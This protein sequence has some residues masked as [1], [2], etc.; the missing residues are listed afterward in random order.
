MKLIWEYPLPTTGRSMEQHFQ[1]S[2]LAGKDYLYYAVGTI[3]EISLHVI[4]VHTGQGT[5]YRFPQSTYFYVSP[6]QFFGFFYKGRAFFY[7]LDLYV[8]EDD[9]IVATVPLSENKEFNSWLLRDNRLYLAIGH[10]PFEELLCIDLDSLQIL[11]SLE[12]GCTKNYRA[13]AISFL[14]GKI[15]CYGLDQLLFVNPED[16]S[17]E[18]QLRFPRIDKIFCPLRQEDGTL[19]IGYTNWTNAGILCYDENAGKILWRYKRKFE[20]PLGNCKIYP[21]GDYVYWTKNDTELI[22]LDMAS[23]EAINRIR[24]A[25][26]RYTDLRFHDRNLLFGT[27]GADGFLNC[28]DSSKCTPKWQIPLKEGCVSFD[29]RHDSVFTGDFSKRIF[30]ISLIDGSISDTLTVDAEVIGCVKVQDDNLYTIL[31]GNEGKPLRLVKIGL[32]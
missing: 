24:T 14:E 16:G 23:G 30:E 29:I 31:W 5:E 3:N 4:N 2:I 12:I 18:K 19:L 21:V 26:W 20:G 7:A 32:S 27:S 6:K 25:P 8:L 15:A 28:L 22:C 1:S 9:Q 13:G 17:I 10:R 11:W